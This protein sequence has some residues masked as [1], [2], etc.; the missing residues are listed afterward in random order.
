MT[1]DPFA[2]QHAIIEAAQTRI[3]EAQEDISAALARIPKPPGVIPRDYDDE[4]DYYE[5]PD[6]YMR[7]L[8]MGRWDAADDAPGR[9]RA[10][11]ALSVMQT[12]TGALRDWCITLN[13]PDELTAQDARRLAAALLDAAAALEASQGHHPE[14]G[15]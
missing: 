15:A 4:W 14:A 5:Q 9:Y 8:T 3:D 1:T 7:P 12:E 11:V 6:A 13:G 2:D 10:H